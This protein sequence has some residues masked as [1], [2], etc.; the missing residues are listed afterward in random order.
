MSYYSYSSTRL[1]MSV[2][3]GEITFIVHVDVFIY[4]HV[5]TVLLDLSLLCLEVGTSL[6]REAPIRVPPMASGRTSRGTS[7]GQGEFL[8]DVLLAFWW[9]FSRGFGECL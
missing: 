7:T 8:W 3:L 5:D 6:S 9:A 2:N 4:V 1:D